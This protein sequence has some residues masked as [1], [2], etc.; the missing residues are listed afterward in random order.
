M[1]AW[2]IIKDVGYGVATFTWYRRV[3]LGG[4]IDVFN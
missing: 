1:Y 4:C 3:L 2:R